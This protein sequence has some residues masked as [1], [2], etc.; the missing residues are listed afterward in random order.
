MFDKKTAYGPVNEAEKKRIADRVK[1]AER[2]IENA[3][4]AAT[5]CFNDGKFKF[6]LEKMALGRM[7][8]VDMMLAIDLDE[9]MQE[10]KLFK[11]LQSKLISLDA[12]RVEVQKDLNR[13]KRSESGKP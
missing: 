4:A 5:L 12:L 7:G 6:Y 9:P 8:L 1:E 10:W 3:T 13:K 11:E 2:L